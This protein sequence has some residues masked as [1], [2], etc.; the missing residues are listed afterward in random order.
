[1]DLTGIRKAVADNARTV[2]GLEDCKHWDSDAQASPAFW[3]EVENI[4]APTMSTPWFVVTLRGRLRVLGTYDRAI[5]DQADRLVD[6][7]WHGLRVDRTLGGL[8]QD[9]EVMNAGYEQDPADDSVVVSYEIVVV[10]TN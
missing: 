4:E 1:M 6:L 2:D 9:I 5:S 3:V 8:A 10:T 7:L